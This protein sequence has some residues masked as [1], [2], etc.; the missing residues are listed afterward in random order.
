MGATV[1]DLRE[2]NPEGDHVVS[3][4]LLTDDS[5]LV[6]FAD[7]MID[8]P[9]GVDELSVVLAVVTRQGD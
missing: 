5:H 2:I 8:M 4:Y 7:I 6:V 1:V 3:S 9:K